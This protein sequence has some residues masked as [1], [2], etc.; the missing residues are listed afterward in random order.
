MNLTEKVKEIRKFAKFGLVTFTEHCHRRALERN[1][2]QNMILDMLK[3]NNNSISQYKEHYK[4][5]THPSYVILAKCRKNKK[6]YHIVVF[7]EISETGGR[8]YSV[9]TV[10]QPSSTYFSH[11]GRYLKKKKD[12]NNRIATV[13]AHL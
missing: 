9:S 7:E 10:Y 6:Y 11:N 8:K 2:T 5:A 4:G 1:V 3:D 13:D 12:R